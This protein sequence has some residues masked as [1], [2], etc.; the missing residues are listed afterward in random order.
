MKKLHVLSSRISAVFH[1]YTNVKTKDCTS[2]ARK[3]CS[4]WLTHQEQWHHRQ[5]C[6]SEP[7]SVPSH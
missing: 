3:Y 2:L 4:R 5:L 7:I 1:L 6:G